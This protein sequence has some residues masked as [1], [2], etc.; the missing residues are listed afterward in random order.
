MFRKVGSEGYHTAALPSERCLCAVI[1][2]VQIEAFPCLSLKCLYWMALGS[3][4]HG[5]GLEYGHGDGHSHGHRHG[6]E[7]GCGHGHGHG[8]R[9]P[10]LSVQ[11]VWCWKTPWQMCWRFMRMHTGVL[12]QGRLLPAPFPCWAFLSSTKAHPLPPMPAG[13]GPW[14]P[15][16]EISPA[17][18]LRLPPA[19]AHT[20]TEPLAQPC[21]LLSS[22]GR[23]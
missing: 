5:H 1:K 16:A 6:H 11:Q 8:W 17:K 12:L 7:Y 3:P 10:F 23:S 18:A 22:Q 9:T 14:L 13:A 21:V 20:S 2:P 4:G 19:A 15:P